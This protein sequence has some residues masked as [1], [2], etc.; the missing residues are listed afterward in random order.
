MLLVDVGSQGVVLLYGGHPLTNDALED[1]WTWDGSNWTQ[2]L[3][4]SPPG[5]LNYSGGAYDA[6]R[7]RVV[8]FGG[9]TGKPAGVRLA[10]TWEWGTPP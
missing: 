2:L 9:S 4:D 10:D 6:A 3:A 1:T 7:G 8:M 5:P